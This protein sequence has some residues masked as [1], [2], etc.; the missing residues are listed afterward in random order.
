MKLFIGE[1]ILVANRDQLV[2]GS[3]FEIKVKLNMREGEI[4]MG[5]NSIHVLKSIG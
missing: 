3:L 4:R 5:A 2:A 1:D